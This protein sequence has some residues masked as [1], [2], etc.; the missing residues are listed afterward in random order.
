M[1]SLG[2]RLQGGGAHA[3]FSWGVLDRLLDEVAAGNLRVDAI[4]GTSVVP[5]AQRRA[6]GRYATVLLP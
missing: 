1:K 4:S 5:S 3:A 2:L 6:N